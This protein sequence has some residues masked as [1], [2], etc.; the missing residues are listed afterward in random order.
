MAFFKARK[1]DIHEGPDGR[2]NLHS[3]PGDAWQ[4][5]LRRHCRQF[6]RVPAEMK[7]SPYQPEKICRRF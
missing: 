3:I 4:I 2:A 7:C 1:T 5:T 6:L